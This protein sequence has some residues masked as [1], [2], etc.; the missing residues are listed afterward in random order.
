MKKLI[1]VI[2]AM[3]LTNSGCR[4]GKINEETDLVDAP[5]NIYRGVPADL[6]G[7]WSGQCQIS[8]DCTS[9]LYI[10][11]Q[12]NKIT[13]RFS[14]VIDEKVHGLTVGPYILENNNIIDNEG[15]SIGAIGHGGFFLTRPDIGKLTAT[16]QE[17]G[18]LFLTI[19][20]NGKE[21]FKAEFPARKKSQTS[22][23][24]NFLSIFASRLAIGFFS[25]N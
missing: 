15:Y 18:D 21:N 5:N 7:S 22:R 24:G 8:K 6:D 17:S 2:L 19:E 20:N 9:E 16:K 23:T 12:A 11:L 10:K 25:Y 1:I 3:L 4:K 14:Y 13:V